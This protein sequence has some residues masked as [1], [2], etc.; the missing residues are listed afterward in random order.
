V[1]GEPLFERLPA[2]QDIGQLSQTLDDPV[3]DGFVS[4]CFHVVASFRFSEY[5]RKDAKGAKKMGNL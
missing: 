2:L 5:R 1:H 3:A 4:F